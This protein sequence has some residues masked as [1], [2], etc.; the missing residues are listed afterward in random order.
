[1]FQDNQKSLEQKL[2]ILFQSQIDTNETLQEL[3]KALHNDHN[4]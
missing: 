3:L 2:D 4:R 1:M